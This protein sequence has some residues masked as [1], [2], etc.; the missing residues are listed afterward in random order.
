MSSQVDMQGLSAT[1][2]NET[3]QIVLV[4]AVQD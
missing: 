2:D 4:N 1:L 3:N